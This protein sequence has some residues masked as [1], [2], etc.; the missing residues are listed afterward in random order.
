MEGIN[1]EREGEVKGGNYVIFGGR[2]SSS[3]R[4]SREGGWIKE[5]L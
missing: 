2:V 1:M 5:S 3:G 4:W